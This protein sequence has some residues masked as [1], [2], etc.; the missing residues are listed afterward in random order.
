MSEDEPQNEEER[1]KFAWMIA[2]GSWMRVKQREGHETV[3]ISQPTIELMLYFFVI[4]W[5]SGKAERPEF[6]PTCY[7][8][9][10]PQEGTHGR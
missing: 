8:E 10:V 3:D 7:T 1:Q 9:T 5:D 6:C 4:G 2:L